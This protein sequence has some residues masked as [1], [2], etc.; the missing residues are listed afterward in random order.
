MAAAGGEAARQ[1]ALA[2]M[3]A[4]PSPGTKRALSLGRHVDAI[5]G[6]RQPDIR[7][8][9][10]VCTR[11]RTGY[12]QAPGLPVLAL[13]GPTGIPA[14]PIPQGQASSLANFGF[15]RGHVGMVVSEG[16][17]DDRSR[18]GRSASGASR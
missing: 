9:G 5:L 12:Q 16:L 2:A 7:E 1:A 3:A 14:P 4:A 13:P 10:Q 6:Q 17:R 8:Y 15:P 18:S 11:G